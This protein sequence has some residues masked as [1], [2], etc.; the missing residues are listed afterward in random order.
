MEENSKNG[1]LEQGRNF[2]TKRYCQML[3]LYNDSQ[4]IEKYR[5]C[6]SQENIWPE[7]PKGIRAVGILD[8]E[9]YIMDNH[10]F[11]IVETPIDF[12][13]D[14]AF[15]KLATMERQAQWEAYVGQFQISDP[16]SSSSEK[17]TLMERMFKLP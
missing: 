17:W 15:G 8:M 11:M 3:D 10:L 1:Y 12:D 6:H 2:T 16:G 4:L 7:I 9:I 5:A 13:W 14:K